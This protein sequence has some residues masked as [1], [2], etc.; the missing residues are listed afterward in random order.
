[1]RH[2][3]ES[4]PLMISR[5]IKDYFPTHVLSTVTYITLRSI[6]ANTFALP[7]VHYFGWGYLERHESEIK[8]RLDDAISAH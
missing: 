3:I 4:L 2:S 1:M 6:N 8:V 7:I 5:I